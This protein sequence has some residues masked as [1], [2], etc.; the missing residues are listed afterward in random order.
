MKTKYL[1]IVAFLLSLIFACSKPQEPKPTPDPGPGPGPEPEPEFIDEPDDESPDFKGSLDYAS[2]PALKH[3]RLL[4]TAAEFEA[5]KKKVTSD[6]VSNMLLYKVHNLIMQQT[7]EYLATPEKIE[8]VLD[9]AGKRLLPQSKKA[10]KRI[11]HFAYAYRMTGE[12]KYLKAAT[13]VME[14]VCS[15]DVKSV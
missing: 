10:L 4:M 14:N 8:P 13:D 11:G 2:L 7:D 12:T 3:P 15:W 5:H 6:R 9:A 1:A